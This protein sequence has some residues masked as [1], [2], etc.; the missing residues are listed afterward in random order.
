MNHPILKMTTRKD[1][2][3]FFLSRPLN[4]YIWKMYGVGTSRVT[5]IDFNDRKAS[6][7]LHGYLT[8]FSLL[9]ME[10]ETTNWMI[11]ID[12][13]DIPHRFKQKEENRIALW[14][15]FL[16]FWSYRCLCFYFCLL[17][18]ECHTLR[19][20]NAHT[21][22]GNVGHLVDERRVCRS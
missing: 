12:E 14:F 19:N 3:F 4:I 20:R 2:T 5:L 17:H 9:R 18:E 13:A 7:L 1:D 22:E 8:R 21:R 6:P 11:E 16:F 15:C 10:R